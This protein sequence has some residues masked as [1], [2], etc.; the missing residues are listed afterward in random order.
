MITPITLQTMDI[1]LMLFVAVA[2]PLIAIISEKYYGSDTLK[3]PKF[4]AMSF[5]A[6]MLMLWV[7]TIALL[8]FWLSEGRPLSLVG[9]GFEAGWWSYG[10]VIASLLIIGFYCREFFKI[11]NDPVEE[12]KVR[13]QLTETPALQDMMPNNKAEVKLMG[14]TALTAGIT[15]EILYRGFLIWGFMFYTN[16]WVAGLLSLFIF[17]VAHLYQKTWDNLIR[18]ASLG[19]LMTAL[20][21]ASGSLYPAI[22]VHIF[23][24]LVATAVGR[25]LHLVDTAQVDADGH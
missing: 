4:K 17:T 18:V 22:A 20:T 10:T 8:W 5:K 1:V 19:A 24:D 11:K 21:I 2:M 7:P 14:L 12:Q 9:L 23:V 15:E 16:I 6:T 13:D 3:N 25:H